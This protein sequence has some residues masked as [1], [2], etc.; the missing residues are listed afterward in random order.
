MLKAGRAAVFLGLVAISLQGCKKSPHEKEAAFLARGETLVA[1]KQYPRAILEFKNAM[2]VMPRDAEPYY[3]LGIAYLDGG[4][5]LD[6]FRAFHRATE[7]DP[8]HSRAQL[9]VAELL[10]LTRKS[11]LLQDAESR[12]GNVL[13]ASPN[14]EEATNALA[15]TEFQLGKKE[16]AAE[17]LEE[18]LRKF[19]SRLKSSVALARIML[20]KKDFKGAEDALQKA[21]VIAPDSSAARLALGQFYMLLGHPEQAEP[22][23]AKAVQL[24]PKNGPAL[25][26]LALLQI[27]AKRMDAAEATLKQLSALPDKRY[28]DLHAMFLY[29]RGAKSAAI[30]ELERLVRDDPGLPANT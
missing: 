10:S 29:K 30:A 7:L 1:A 14:D 28:R 8:K 5:T 13:A 20:L 3:Q 23:I 22:E 2:R 17:R 24:D 16:D 21:V 11:N 27:G 12:L 9:K 25:L 6:A 19:P 4:D 15:I 26:S 18:S